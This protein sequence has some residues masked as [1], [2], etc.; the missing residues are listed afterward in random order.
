MPNTTAAKL[1][2]TEV[3][4]DLT[5][6]GGIASVQLTFPYAPCPSLKQ[7]FTYSVMVDDGAP[8]HDAD[9]MYVFTDA[10]VELQTVTFIDPAMPPLE[11]SLQAFN[12]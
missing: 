10:C 1:T 12:V 5:V 8:E 3:A 6:G 7:V 2:T 9:P 4:D 11:I